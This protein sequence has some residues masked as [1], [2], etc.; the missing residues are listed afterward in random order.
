MLEGATGQLDDFVDLEALYEPD[1]SGLLSTGE[2]WK[3]VVDWYKGTHPD[4][5]SIE[6]DPYEDLPPDFT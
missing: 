5:N 6:L 2:Y 1:D 3:R 4:D